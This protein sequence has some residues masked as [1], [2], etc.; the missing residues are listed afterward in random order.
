MKTSPSAVLEALLHGAGKVDQETAFNYNLSYAFF[1][2]RKLHEAVQT[3]PFLC[4]KSSEWCRTVSRKNASEMLLCCPEDVMKSNHCRHN[5]TSLC[6]KCKI[7]ICDECWNLLCRGQKIPK[8][9]CNDNYISYQHEFIVRE[10]VT[11]LEATIACPIFT[12]LITYYVEGKN[13]ERGH[14]MEEAVGSPQRAYAIR[15]NCFSFLLPWD[16]VIG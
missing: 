11:W 7:P 13:T 5:E 1:K 14:L 9:L 10:K 6:S 15:G 8:A 3:D 4:G 16:T 2:K 12:G